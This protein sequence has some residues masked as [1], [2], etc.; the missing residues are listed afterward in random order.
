MV[1]NADTQICGVMGKRPAV[2]KSSYLMAE[3]PAT[4]LAVVRVMAAE[5]EAY[6]LGD[7]LYR[8]ITISIGGGKQNLQM[9]GADL[10]TRL[11]RLDGMTAQLSAAERADLHAQQ[12]HISAITSRFAHQFQARLQREIK[13][14]LDG[15][16]WFLDDCA[17]NNLR[18]HIDF[19]FEM[20]NRKSA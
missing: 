16:Q 13:A 4:D 9:T 7:Q 2:Q 10:L 12:A 3:A 14:R 18:C 20:R 8:T 17:A 19:P 6:L 1:L 5:L 11:Q 15:L